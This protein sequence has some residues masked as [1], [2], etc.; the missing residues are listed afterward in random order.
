MIFNTLKIR[1]E[2]CSKASVETISAFCDRG[3]VMKVISCSIW[4]IYLRLSLK[5]LE[6]AGIKIITIMIR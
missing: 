1:Q 5:K 6:G 2:L 4:D 3:E